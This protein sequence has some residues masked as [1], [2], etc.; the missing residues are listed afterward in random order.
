MK[1]RIPTFD[2]FINE[3]VKRAKTD[4]RVVELNK[5]LLLNNSRGVDNNHIMEIPMNWD[6]F[7]KF[8]NVPKKEMMAQ[9]NCYENALIFAKNNPE[10]KLVLG[11]FIYWKNFEAEKKWMASGDDHKFNPFHMIYPHAWN[12]NSKDEI[13]D[14]TIDNSD[15]DCIYVGTIIDANKYNKGFGELM[16]LVNKLLKRKV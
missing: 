14:V 3:A 11:I 10:Y 15:R 1:Q 12:I 8:A 4:K 6:V 13:Y 2:L 16:P 7:N 5:L 9:S